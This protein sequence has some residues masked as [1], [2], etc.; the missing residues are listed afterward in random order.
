MKAAAILKGL[1]SDEWIV[2]ILI[3]AIA[4]VPRVYVALNDRSLPMSDERTYDK[5]AW[6]FA[7]NEGRVEKGKY[8][9]HP[10]GSF[11]YRPPGYPLFL[12]LIYKAF[13][14]SY[15]AAR[16]IQAVLG[17]ASCALIYLIGQ[18]IFDK[19][20][21][22]ISAIL[23]ATY[24]LMI[25]VSSFLLSE[26][27]FVF[28]LQ[29]F[30]LLA[31][32]ARE[33]GDRG[34]IF[35]AGTL[36][37]LATITR[38]VTLPLIPLFFLWLLSSTEFR[39]GRPIK[40][41]AL[42]LALSLTIGPIV[43]KNYQI[44]REFIPISTHGGITF[45][46]GL[47]KGDN[48]RDPEI[49]LAGKEIA[50]SGLSELEQERRYYEVSIN[51]LKEHPGDIPHILKR[52]I[53]L[54][55]IPT[56]YEIAHKRVVVA[57]DPWFWYS[58]L[59][60]AIL[61]IVTYPRKS[62]PGRALLYLV[63]A[64]QV[65]MVALYDSSVRYRIPLIPPLS[66]LA[67]F[68]AAELFRA[69]KRP[70]AW[71]E[72]GIRGKGIRGAHLIALVIALLGLGYYLHHINCWFAYDDEGGYLYAAWRIGEGEMPYRDF[73]TPKLP[74]F[75]YP[76]ALLLKLSGNSVLALRAASALA[77]TSSA[78]LLYLTVRRL[79]GA[80]T[81]LLA[82]ALFMVHR[83]VYWSAR[84]FRPEAY[85]LLYAAAGIYLFARS[86][87]QG[88]LGLAASGLLFA[89][90]TLTRLFGSLPLAGCVL[91]M[92]YDAIRRCLGKLK[93][94][95]WSI[96]AFSFQ[97]LWE[98][99]KRA[100]WLLVPYIALVGAGFA[101]FY[102]LTPNFFAAILGHHLR[103]GSELGRSQ[104]FLKG[105]RLYWSYLRG[106][107]L[108]LLLTVPAL[109]RSF[110]AKDRLQ[111]LF[112][113]QI[114]T[115]AILLVLS[116]E[117]GERHLVHLVPS[118]S[119]LFAASLTSSLS[120][121]LLQRAFGRKSR[122]IIAAL[123]I[124][125]ALWP[126]WQKNRLVAS[127][128]ENDTQALA[129]YIQAHTEEDDYVLSDYPGIN[130]HAR[131]RNTPLG[132]GLSR[133]AALGGQIW[134]KD[135]IREIEEKQ[136][137]MVLVNIAQGAHQMANLRDY[138]G[139]HR[140]VQDHFHLAGR[141]IQDYRLLEV[142]HREDLMPTPLEVN[143]GDKIMLTG[144][145]W[146]DGPM[147][148][149]DPSR[150]VGLEAIDDELSQ[151]LPLQFCGG[152][153]DSSSE[154]GGE[155]VVTL[156]WRALADMEE[157]YYLVLRLMDEEGKVWGL[158]QKQ[159]M[160]IET[161]TY[162][163]EEGLERA[164]EFPT[165]QWPVGEV[166]LD[167]YKLPV[168]P[169]TPPGRYQIMAR[170]RTLDAWEG[171]KVLSPSS[172]LPGLDYPLGTL[173]VTRPAQPPSLAQLAIPHP[174]MEELGGE[175]QLLGYKL[176]ATE[177]RPG[178]MV[179]LTLFW[180]A[181]RWMGREYGLLLKLQD[182]EGNVWAEGR[183]PLTRATYP[184][185]QWTEGEMVRGQYDLLVDAAAPAGECR[186]ALDLVDRSTGRRL[187][188]RDL[189]FAKLRVVGRERRFAVPE[190]I[191]HPLRARLGDLVTLLGY[192]LA[193]MEVEPGGTL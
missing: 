129:E 82:M 159:L 11:T 47:L 186:L 126:S 33:R 17:A 3:F 167:Y 180:R 68:S 150:S 118:L 62:L 166:V 191:Q 155:L 173:E 22:L 104:V 14:H 192:D 70:G 86:Y 32:A 133:G 18:R 111:A 187:L 54:L 146:G 57:Q 5:Y 77:V 13:G 120:G 73:L 49:M 127:W 97:L 90:A 74:L 26:T 171:L 10:L 78:F 189:A 42:L 30:I 170:L 37:G 102:R 156:R 106:H 98:I 115:A 160:D 34:A 188:G 6:S 107:P 172:T 152:L 177:A 27:L 178:D 72:N 161:E 151:S 64:T 89:M 105:L 96:S 190:A 139:F 142:Y 113:S 45:Y 135:L 193:E 46:R 153:C 39:R 103:Q 88:R 81:A 183:F 124:A 145:A 12:G 76:G 116:R 56:T 59:G 101:L 147:D 181:L 141:A 25:Q 1:L 148:L 9:Y 35:W 114:P 65:A 128:R 36:L 92:A 4:L 117:L 84:F 132:A 137:K 131:R 157:D 69:L 16:A 40:A 162:W 125:L 99:G 15:P 138:D 66:I 112:A 50:E 52:K 154:A 24:P 174:F 93:A 87:P 21:G 43:V 175:V 91:F 184:T 19:I 100:L 130:F 143:F 41:L 61:G 44:H 2:F 110:R 122:L 179:H 60:F 75:L 119:A 158:G 7:Q 48:L 38:P 134:G 29:A 67:S 163:D 169:G 149:I 136:V 94:R 83:D 144:L 123:L 85:M 185:T 53:E 20:V 176:A 95:S 79:F 23:V 165:S 55:F 80:G 109:V 164:V 28:L 182:A 58:I 168:P 31:L 108:F 51:Y 71:G 63:I 140:Y 8:I 121:G